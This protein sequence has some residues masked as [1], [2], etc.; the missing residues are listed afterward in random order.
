MPTRREELAQL[1][2]AREH[3]PREL[4]ELT[5]ARVR[6]VLDDL[7]HVRRSHGRAFRVRPAE[8]LACGFAFADRRRLGTPSRCPRCRAERVVGPWL[9]VRRG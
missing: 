9:S 7:E 3:T 8:C 5:A 4:A 1:I 2:E 6:D